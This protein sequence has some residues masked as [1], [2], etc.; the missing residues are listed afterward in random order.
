MAEQRFREAELFYGHGTDNPHDEAVYLVLR[1]L[2]LSFDVDDRRLDAPLEPAQIQ[3]IKTLV[4]KRITQRIPTAYLVNEAWFAGLPFYVD[5]RVLI[6]RSPIAELIEERFSPWIQES[7]VKR[8]LDIGTGS[9][10][11]AIA[12]AK[13]FP[14]AEVDATDISSDALEVAKKNVVNHRLSDQVTL[15]E[16]DLFKQLYKQPYDL[17]VSNPPYVGSNELSSLPAEYSHEPVNA[18]TPGQDGLLLIEK[19]LNQSARYLSE[20]GVLVVEVGNGQGIVTET[21]PGI[22]F[23]W[24]EFEYGG[25]GVFLLTAE[26]LNEFQI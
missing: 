4:D 10:C 9:A 22:P 26:Q 24:L 8:I 23:T 20:H 3:H 6:P 7:S 13:A 25:E 11:I 19:I 12:C 17:I 14:D 1:G 5:E 21:F 16:S 2:D 15:Y 18:L